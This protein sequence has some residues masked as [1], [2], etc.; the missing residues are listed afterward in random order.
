MRDFLLINNT[1]SLYSFTTPVQ[2]P[3]AGTTNSSA[4]VG[5]VEASG[6]ATTWLAVT[7]DPRNNYL[8]CMDWA[9]NSSDVLVQQLD[10]RQQ[11]RT[12]WM[13]NAASGQ[14]RSIFVERDSAWV[15]IYDDLVGYG[16]GPSVHWVGGNKEFLILARSTRIPVH[17]IVA[18]Q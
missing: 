7:G 16:R 3:K 18:V 4:R 17:D 8:A 14:V 5:V 1:D 12:F 15:D 11:M 2:Y 6:G 13:G 9:A 10:R